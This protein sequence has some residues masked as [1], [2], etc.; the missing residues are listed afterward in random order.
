[1]CVCW[2]RQAVVIEEKFVGEEFSLM[3]FCETRGYGA[4]WSCGTAR[5]A[6][7]AVLVKRALGVLAEHV[8]FSFG[9]MPGVDAHD[10]HGEGRCV[11]VAFAGFDLLA[12][13][14]PHR[15]RSEPQRARRATWTEQLTEHL[16]EQHAAGRAH[17]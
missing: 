12:I 17:G 10:H 16:R 4:F 3:S 5:S 15:G 2:T 9:C 8:S 14:T 7:T 1:M 6:G 13:Y 11:A